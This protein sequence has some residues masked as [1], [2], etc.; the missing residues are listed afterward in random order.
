MDSPLVIKLM[1]CAQAIADGDL[2]FADQL[3]SE[4]EALSA[5]ETNRVTRKVVEYF[6][7]ALAR[8]VHGV[9]PRNP[10]PLLPSSN[11]K[12]IRDRKSVV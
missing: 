7:E 11:L 10:F 1:D 3:F 6:A 12:K 2:K 9:H 8:R 4:M 5:A